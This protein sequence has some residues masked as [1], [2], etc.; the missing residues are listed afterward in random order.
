MKLSVNTPGPLCELNE[1]TLP[2]LC[3]DIAPCMYERVLWIGVEND[4]DSDDE[5]P[6]GTVH[7]RG[8][9]RV[10]MRCVR[11]SPMRD[12]SDEPDYP[13][14]NKGAVSWI[15]IN[16]IYQGHPFALILAS[17]FRD[18]VQGRSICPEGMPEEAKTTLRTFAKKAVGVLR[19]AL[20]AYAASDYRK[21]EEAMDEF[22]NRYKVEE[23]EP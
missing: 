10:E 5:T 6:W 14:Y 16:A 21:G 9:N 13:R 22:A 3:A 19:D 12:P 17:D 4:P 15:E 18:K 7:S 23:A 11:Q 1:A 20:M 2:R 8:V